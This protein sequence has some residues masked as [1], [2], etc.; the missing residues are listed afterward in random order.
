MYNYSPKHVGEELYMIKEI[1]LT[2]KFCSLRSMNSK[3]PIFKNSYMF[4]PSQTVISL[5]IQGLNNE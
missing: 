2:P 5:S 3:L 4:R 1:L